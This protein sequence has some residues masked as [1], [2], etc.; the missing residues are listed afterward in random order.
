[1]NWIT[2][3]ADTNGSDVDDED[4]VPGFDSRGVHRSPDEQQKRT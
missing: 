1:M 2:V 4:H 3:S